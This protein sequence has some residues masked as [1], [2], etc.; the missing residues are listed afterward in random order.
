MKF[1]KRPESIVHEYNI[2]SSIYLVC[3]CGERLCYRYT[4]RAH[5][6]TVY[7]YSRH[8]IS[9]VTYEDDKVI[10]RCKNVIGICNKHSAKL[11]NRMVHFTYKPIEM[12]W[13]GFVATEN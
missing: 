11:D 4:M 9:K 7:L 3:K 13:N 8:H 2:I 10:C 12:N 1:N 5:S 6:R